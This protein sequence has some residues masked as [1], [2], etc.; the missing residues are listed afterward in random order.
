[1]A[2]TVG[3]DVQICRVDGIVLDVFDT[4]GA[5]RYAAIASCYFRHAEV[6]VLVYDVM[7]PE[8]FQGQRAMM[9]TSTPFSAEAWIAK[10]KNDEIVDYDNVQII[11]VAN[12]TDLECEIDSQVTYPR[13][14]STE[15]GKDFARSLGPNACYIETSAKY[16][17]GVQELFNIVAKRSLQNYSL[18]SYL[19]EKEDVDLVEKRKSS[20]VDLTQPKCSIGQSTSSC[21]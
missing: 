16:G 9:N 5:E 3:A 12:K 15:E 11:V 20:A 14:V 18:E 21:C 1:M 7:E 13:L 4:S 8:T 17:D 19:A 10:V 6:I 2:A